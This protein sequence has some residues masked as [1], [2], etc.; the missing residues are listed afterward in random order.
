MP[1]YERETEL[2]EE[3]K[4]L[5]LKAYDSIKDMMLNYEIV[6]GQRL[7]FVDLAKRLGVSRTPVNNAL[8]ILAKEGYLDFVPNQGY[9]VHKL[10]RHEAESLYEIREILE[11]GIIGK[12]LRNMTAE[13]MK[14]IS[15]ARENYENSVKKRVLRRQFILDTEFHGSIV[16]VVKNP[17]IS[18]QYR[19]VSQ[20]MFLRFRIENLEL[21]RLNEIIHEHGNLHEAILMKDVSRAKELIKNHYANSQRNLFRIIFKDA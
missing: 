20:K 13:D 3:T 5:T 21:P 4:N 7:V 11:L 12:A 14:R 8:G 18:E 17:Y 9:W 6:P 16:D 15:Q 19:E 1:V 2:K 10:T